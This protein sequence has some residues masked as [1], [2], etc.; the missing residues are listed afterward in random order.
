[1]IYPRCV[2]CGRPLPPKVDGAIAMVG[3]L[4]DG[5]IKMGPVCPGAC[6]GEEPDEFS[7][8]HAAAVAAVVFAID[9]MPDDLSALDSG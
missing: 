3:Y 1:M 8:I 2:R 4:I 6:P 7:Q 5:E 9:P